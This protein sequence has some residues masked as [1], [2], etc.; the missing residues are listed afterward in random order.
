MTLGSATLESAENVKWAEN[1]LPFQSF[2][3]GHTFRK[4]LLKTNLSTTGL[5]SGILHKKSLGN[6]NSDH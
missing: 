3:I 5:L 1:K 2:R 4:H 6:M